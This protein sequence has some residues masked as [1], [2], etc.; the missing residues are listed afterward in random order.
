MG[1]A[2][3]APWPLLSGA[4]DCKQKKMTRDFRRGSRPLVSG[5]FRD[6]TGPRYVDEGF[7]QQS[8]RVLFR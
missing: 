8:R 5:D 4:Q 2:E 7:R 1:H 3:I 6:E